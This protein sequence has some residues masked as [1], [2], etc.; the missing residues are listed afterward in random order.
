[1]EKIYFEPVGIVKN[2][3]NE[4]TDWHEIKSKPSTI[5]IDYKW[6]EAL[7]NIGECEYLDI[8]FYFH[9]SDGYELSGQIPSGA[10]R[11]RALLLDRAAQP[12]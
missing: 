7:L 10:Q 3:F 12:G 6:Q 8:V 5:H 2:E 9:A 4:P 1:M 11:G